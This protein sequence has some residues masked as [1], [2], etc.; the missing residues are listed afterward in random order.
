MSFRCAAVAQLIRHARP[1]NRAY[2]F[3]FSRVRRLAKRKRETC[4]RDVPYVFGP[5]AAGFSMLLTKPF[6]VPSSNMGQTLQ[7]QEILMARKTANV[8]SV[9]CLRPRLHG[10]LVFGLDYAGRSTASVLRS[11]DRQLERRTHALHWH[12]KEE[13]GQADGMFIR[14]RDGPYGAM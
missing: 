5:V 12:P 2:D 7:R 3:E 8:A 14:P 10:D 4:A 13:P 9:R 6:S 11:H 1:G